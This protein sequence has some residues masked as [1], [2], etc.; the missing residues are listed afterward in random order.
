MTIP[1]LGCGPNFHPHK[2]YTDALLLVNPLSWGNLHGWKMKFVLVIKMYIN[3][4]QDDKVLG[5][6]KFVDDKL[7]LTQ[8]IKVM[9]HRMENVGKK[10]ML[11]NSIFFFSNVFKRLFPS[12]CQKSSLCGKGLTLHVTIMSFNDPGKKAFWKN[13]GKRRNSWC[14]FAIY[15]Y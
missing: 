6:Q 4:L 2:I 14:I 15:M 10:K 12:V 11:V 9:L 3:P 13:C 5:L 1:H 8:N 7:N